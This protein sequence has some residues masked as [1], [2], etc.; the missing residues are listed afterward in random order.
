M[1]DDVLK[2]DTPIGNVDPDIRVGFVLSPR[3]TLTPFANFVD[4]LRLAADDADQSRQI[5][6]HWSVVAPDLEPVEASCGVLVTPLE[7]FPDP[8]QFDYVV[9]VGGLLPGCLDQSAETYD[10]L[11]HA[12]ASG[13]T[14]VGVC[15]GS[16][17]LAQAGL[18]DGR[19]C[20][21]HFDHRH[22][23]ASMFPLVRPVTEKIFAGDSG[24]ITCPGGTAALDLAVSLIEEHCGRA[25]AIKGLMSM[26]VD[27]RRGG[28]QLLH[29]PYGNL[30]ACGNWRVERSIELMER[31][32][33]R[34]FAIGELAHRLGTSVRELNR[35]FTNHAKQSP[36]SIWRTM[37][38]AHAHWL[39][40]NTSRN[41]TQVAFECGFADTAHFSRWFRR[42]YNETPST[43]RRQRRLA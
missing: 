38:L 9:V 15:T 20:A 27:N 36:A 10:F 29:R 18:L 5:H 12:H 40:L 35:A 31:N 43:F 37:R 24:V 8:T 19:V 23:M 2:I 33:S 13:V 30:T 39:L 14:V 34:P 26:L 28:H 21:V 3:F 25:R 7:V 22:Q 42:S 41:V 17:V 11:R 6:C 1:A 4:C 32:I 16:F